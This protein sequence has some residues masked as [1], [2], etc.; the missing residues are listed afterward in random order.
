[1]A[2]SELKLVTGASQIKYEQYHKRA[3]ALEEAVHWG[4]SLKMDYKVSL[5]Y[6]IF[7]ILLG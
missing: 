1:M 4:A 5:L 7:Q 6:I 3:W 2:S